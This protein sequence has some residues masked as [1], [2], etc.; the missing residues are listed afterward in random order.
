MRNKLKYLILTSLIL[1]SQNNF[2]QSSSN[3][4]LSVFPATDNIVPFRI[5]DEGKPF[6]IMWGLDTAWAS[7]ENIKRG[8]NYLGQ[9]LIDVVRVSFQPTHALENNDLTQIQKDSIDI[10]IKMVDLTGPDTKVA[11]NCDHP[12]V[13]DY[14]VGNAEHWAQ[15]I[16][17]TA[18]RFQEA[19]RE[20]VSVA[21]F[22]EP[23]YTATGQGTIEDFKN[24]A[25]ELKKNP[26][27]DNIR[28][29]GGNTLNTDQALPWYNY[30][31]EYL[32][33][34]NTHQLAG[35]FDNYAAFYETVRANGDYA[36][37]DELHNVM[38]AI[39][40]VEYGLQTGIWWGTTDYAR[41]EFVKAS[42]G[43]RL[44]YSENRPNWTAAA[45][46]RNPQGKVQGFVGSSE[47]QALPTSFRFISETGDVFFNGYGPQREFIVNI[48]G[49]EPGSYMD[50]QTS[51]ECVVDISSG[52]D[53][54]SPIN[55][56]YVLYNKGANKV[57][58]IDKSSITAGANIMTDTYNS[59]YKYQ[60][61]DVTPVAT[62]IGG[63]FSYFFI[64]NVQNG[65][66]LDILN[67]SLEDGGNIIAY[68]HAGGT[69]QQYF[70]EYAGDGWY[71]IRS[72]HSA[73]CLQSSG[74]YVKQGIKE[75]DN[76]YQLWRFLPSNIRRTRTTVPDAPTDVTA[77]AGPTTVT[78]SW[79]PADNA[80]SYIVLRGEKA[81]GP[82]ELIG[83]DFSDTCFIDNKAEAGIKYYYVVKSKTDTQFTSGYSNEIGAELTGKDDIILHY[84]FEQNLNDTTGNMRD[85]K[86]LLAPTWSEAENHGNTLTLD[87]ENFLQLP[88]TCCNNKQLTIATWI[89]LN[90]TNEWQRVFD[91]GCDENR[92]MFLTPRSDDRTI[93]FAIKNG[94]E[95]QY[96]E[97]DVS[98]P[99]I[100]HKW[101]HIAVTLDDEKV[102][103]Y[104]NGE[105]VASSSDIT[106]RPSDF[107]PFANYIGRSQFATDPMFKGNIDDFMI[108]NYPLNAE[109]IK[110][111]YNGEA[112]AVQEATTDN[113]A[114][115]IG[116][117][118]VD[119]HLTINWNRPN[120]EAI[121]SVYNMQGICLLNSNLSYGENQ[122]NAS[123]WPEGIY[124]LSIKYD[125]KE[126]SAKFTVKH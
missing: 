125:K 19:G 69:N 89:Y 103:L 18:Q 63:D 16:D 32:D 40:G 66:S 6:P 33:E 75:A 90:S 39:V 93:R 88:T 59:T 98:T 38:E 51:A 37:N 94:G 25:A 87:G 34:G 21:P 31:K 48:P 45:V 81:G 118:P 54:P 78:L 108:F 58:G 97:T 52:E 73:L 123:T 92:Y 96:I 30:L 7:E 35:T 5:Q 122:F 95:E 62:T 109:A 26:R 85:A 105:A 100:W 121:A 117:L 20:V 10:R 112:V 106:I 84:A 83:R 15:L 110:A 60:K 68:N 28:I 107:K 65:L 11:L 13:D 76:D 104:L 4:S 44:A 29:S 22:N 50:G 67:W 120:E 71:Y 49:G 36:T 53:V 72:R 119:K 86:A 42:D 46:Y 82:Y 116:S 1:G 124:M 9:E 99:D 8:V 74:G 102:T 14:Y 70:I 57:M 56:Q 115:S 77:T 23:D 61:W 91:F 126:E 55:G 3:S 43:T 80:T 114:F 111:L 2:A 101:N 41:A 27:F 17:L 24:I 47:R 79:T 113:K 64:T 12:H